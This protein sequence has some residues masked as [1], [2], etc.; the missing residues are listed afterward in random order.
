ML[1][2]LRGASAR[3]DEELIE[4]LE[5]EP[6]LAKPLRVLSGGT[7]QKVNAVMAFLFS[8]ELLVLDEPTAGLDPLSSRIL[9]DKILSASASGRTFIVTSHIMNELEE[10]ADDVAF[11]LEGRALFVGTL[12]ELKRITCQ[13]TLERAIASMMRRGSLTEAA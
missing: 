2:D 10:L 1:K 11:M 7:R 4:L 12:E 3:L 6:A 8:P 5:L 13:T 9:K